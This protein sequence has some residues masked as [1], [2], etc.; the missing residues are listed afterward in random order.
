LEQFTKRL[1]LGQV[2]ARRLKPAVETDKM[3]VDPLSRRNRRV[4]A[5]DRSVHSRS[6]SAF[7]P[8]FW[9]WRDFLGTRPPRKPL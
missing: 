3:G 2:A 4:L 7:L 6:S 5:A 8:N 9:D 1:S